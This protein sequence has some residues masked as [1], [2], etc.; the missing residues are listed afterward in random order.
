MTADSKNT[1]DAFYISLKGV[2]ESE[3]AN[4]N[5]QNRYVV[6]LKSDVLFKSGNGTSKNPYQ[7]R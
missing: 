3:Y 4:T 6:A 2:A 1:H 7:I 5:A